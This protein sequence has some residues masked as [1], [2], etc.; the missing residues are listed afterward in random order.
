MG[1]PEPTYVEPEPAYVQP[2]PEPVYVPVQEPVYQSPPVHI[3]VYKPPPPPVYQPAPAPVPAA[4]PS[5]V[6]API[7]MSFT[8][9]DVRRQSGG[10]REQTQFKSTESAFVPVQKPI[11]Q[12]FIPAPKAA[13]TEIPK[14]KP[15]P[16]PKFGG[17][18]TAAWP[19][20]PHEMEPG[21]IPWGPK[22]LSQSMEHLAV[23]EAPSVPIQ[24]QEAPPVM[25]ASSTSVVDNRKSW[26]GQTVTTKI[27]EEM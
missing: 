19:P 4:A 13:A 23:T 18:K 11:S 12:P 16:A 25:Y 1:E 8:G 26:H 20:Q 9:L 14:S 21:R 17:K 3:P 5:P 10:I 15:M 24:P 6:P 27:T 7:N 22:A 2:E